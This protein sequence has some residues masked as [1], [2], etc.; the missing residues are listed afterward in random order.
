[1]GRGVLSRPGRDRL[2]QNRSLP[3]VYR[4]GWE[5]GREP[6]AQGEQARDARL[7]LVEAALIAADEPLTPRRLA[8]VAGLAD[9]GEARRLVRRLQAL[10]DE[11]G[12]AFQVEEIAGG[13]QLLTR[14]EYHPW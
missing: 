6:T 9:A 8:D 2:P 14:P 11:D 12:T 10:Y 13:Y 5:G 1:M 4:L 7:A 3:A